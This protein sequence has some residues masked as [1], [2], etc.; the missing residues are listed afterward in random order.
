MTGGELL[1]IVTGGAKAISSAKNALDPDSDIKSELAKQASANVHFAAAA[2][3]RA[4]RALVSQVVLLKFMQPIGMLMK[5]KSD[6]FA[7]VFPQQ[8]AERVA[9]IPEEHVREPKAYVVVPA[10][11]NIS[12]V[13]DEPTLRDLYLNLIAGAMDDRIG[14]S[15]THP[16]FVQVISQ[17]GPDEAAILRSMWRAATVWGV[18]Q[19]HHYTKGNEDGRF[20]PNGGYKWGFIAPD[21]D[22]YYTFDGISIYLTNWR[23]L[24]LI[25]LDMANILTRDG[26][27][28]WLEKD[29]EYISMKAKH[30]E[31]IRVVRGAVYLTDYGRSFCKAVGILD[32]D[33]WS[34]YGSLSEEEQESREHSEPGQSWAAPE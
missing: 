28:E 1:P 20:L 34:P 32:A 30:G 23:R 17:L 24:G 9:Q 18:V 10:V 13:A 29:D 21:E 2:E 22:K 7:N 11:E 25:N 12:N 15:G 8:L 19:L 4:K 26:A 31:N 27:Y 33:A 5:F 3:L 14:E 16:S 6:Y